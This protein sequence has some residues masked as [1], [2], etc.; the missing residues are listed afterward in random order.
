[1]A[2]IRL[3]TGEDGKSHFE[4]V[5]P[6]LAPGPPAAD[7]TV[8]YY[9]EDVDI[10]EGGNVVSHDGAWRVDAAQNKAG[11]LMPGDPMPETKFFQ[12]NAPDIAEDR[13]A[14]L[15]IEDSI[16]VPAGTFADVLHAIDWN[17]LEGE[18]SRD[19]EDKYYAPGIGLVVD[20][21]VE[22]ISFSL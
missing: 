5:E 8:C 17:P 7:G 6:K 12:E 15:G 19:A 11:I 9:G 4:T 16:T 3:Y 21:V 1:M 13:S 22:L 20:D 10:Y 14:I 2:I 18:G